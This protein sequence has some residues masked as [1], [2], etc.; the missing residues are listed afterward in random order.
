M[1]LPTEPL[2]RRK[3][4]RR[5]FFRATLAAGL[6]AAAWTRFIE[7]W[8][9]KTTQHTVPLGLGGGSLRLL[10]LSDL[11][12]APMPLDHLAKSVHAGLALKPDLICVTGDLITTTYDQWDAYATI[13]ADLPKVAPTFAVL[14]NHDGGAWARHHGYADTVRVRELLAAAKISLLHNTSVPF[15]H[16]RGRLRLVGVGDWWA[17][18]I[19]TVSAFRGLSPVRGIPTVLLSHNPDSKDRL[20]WQHWDLMLSGHT[21]GGQLSLPFFGEPFAPVRDK[22]YVRDL[23]RIGDRWLHITAGIGCLHTARFNC[24]PEISLLTLV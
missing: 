15:D 2:P 20:R 7:P 13:L 22:R 10:H 5:T 19:D 1:S 14:G 16:A 4:S 21:H 9:L 17:D 8:W 24:R 3:W 23:H 12:A 18:E 6:G 11:H